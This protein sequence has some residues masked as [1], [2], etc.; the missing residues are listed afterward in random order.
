MCHRSATRASAVSGQ[1]GENRIGIQCRCHLVRGSAD[2]PGCGRKAGRYTTARGVFVAGSSARIT[3][4]RAPG[5]RS[6]NI[7]SEAARRVSMF[8]AVRCFSKAIAAFTGSRGP[9]IQTPLIDRMRIGMIRPSHLPRLPIAAPCPLQNFCDAGLDQGQ[10]LQG[11]KP[12]VGI[13]DQGQADVIA[14]GAIEQAQGDR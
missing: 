8:A 11:R 5:V 1:S 10:T 4:F 12:V 9:G 14:A 3:R 7:A 13:L 6:A 2:F